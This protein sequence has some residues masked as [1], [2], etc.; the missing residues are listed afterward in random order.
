MPDTDPTPLQ[1]PQPQVEARLPAQTLRTLRQAIAPKLGAV[2]SCGRAAPADPL[3]VS[4]LF[5]SISSLAGFSGH[6]NYAAANAALDAAAQ[7]QAACG[8]PA[9]AVQWGAWASVGEAAACM[10][11]LCMCWRLRSDGDH[12]PLANKRCSP[13]HSMQAWCTTQRALAGSRRP[14]WAC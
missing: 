14:R 2:H 12:A 5:S 9:V 13:P 6:A 8:T 7:H 1:L 4:L 10:M 11:L 3:A